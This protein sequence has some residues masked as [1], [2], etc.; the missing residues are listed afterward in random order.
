MFVF[1]L[2]IF[3]L[4][5]AALVFVIPPLLRQENYTEESRQTSTNVTIY[6]ERLQELEQEKLSDEDFQQRKQELEKS[7]AQ[8]LDSQQIT[9]RSQ[10]RWASVIA[11]V[12]I[13]PAIALGLYG[14]YGRY[15][16]LQSVEAKQAQNHGQ[17]ASNFEKMVDG[18]AKRLESQPN[19][20]E[21]HYMLARSYAMLQ[22]YPEAIEV[23]NKLV[24][25]TEGKDPNILVDYAEVAATANGNQ[26]AGL[27]TM[28]LKNALEI[29]PNHVSAL[30]LL[31]FSAQEQNQLQQALEYWEHLLPL[32]PE[33]EEK[34]ITNL[35]TQIN[36]VRQ[37]LGLPVIE[38]TETIAEAPEES[39]QE[40]AEVT[41]TGNIQVSV[42]LDSNL[43]DK[44]QAGDTLFIYARATKGSPMPLAIVRLPASAL[45][46][47]AT[48]DD[49]QAM[50]AGMKLSNFEEVTVMARISKSGGAAEQSGDLKGIVTPVTLGQTVEVVIDQVVP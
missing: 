32:L 34:T 40:T 15:D 37:A 30:W 28:L 17:G 6:K 45:P 29:D 18:L 14:N 33:K 50:M 10:G 44:V 41:A 21:G 48:L 13:V 36:Q 20:L 5:V 27:P 9:Y 39:V 8:E 3:L 49:S 1:W 4:T 25:I 47:K 7:L 12:I 38:A 23:Y 11:V 42:R 16:L 19:D 24:T 2:T 35:T 46:A 26:L 43:Q 22:R 31:G